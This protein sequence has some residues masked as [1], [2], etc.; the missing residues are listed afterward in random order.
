[1][2][3]RQASIRRQARTAR[4][5]IE[6]LVPDGEVA[7]HASLISELERRAETPCAAVDDVM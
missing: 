1:M 4:R 5:G 3:Q 6:D 7:E 2:E